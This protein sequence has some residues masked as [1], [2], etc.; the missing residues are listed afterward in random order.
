MQG[1]ANSTTE[2]HLVEQLTNFLDLF[3]SGQHPFIRLELLNEFVDPLHLL[4]I[5]I[6]PM[7]EK[8]TK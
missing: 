6:L 8:I 2:T 5:A 3:Q 4:R 1:W 7:G